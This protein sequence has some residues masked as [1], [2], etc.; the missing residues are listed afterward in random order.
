MSHQYCYALI[1]TI[2]TNSF[3]HEKKT[4]LLLLQRNVDQYVVTVV[5]QQNQYVVT[6]LKQRKNVRIHL[7]CLQKKYIFNTNDKTVTNFL[8]HAH[9]NFLQ[10][11]EN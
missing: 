11:D 4:G 2:L 7:Q 5:K 1:I 6:V 3:N 9:H 8:F 10:N